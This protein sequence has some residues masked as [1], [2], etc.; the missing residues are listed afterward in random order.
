MLYNQVIPTSCLHV[1]SNR[2]D[3]L[4]TAMNDFCNLT[5][6]SHEDRLPGMYKYKSVHFKN[7]TKGASWDSGDKSSC[8]FFWLSHSADCFTA[9]SQ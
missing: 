4:F 8:V 1:P 6:P 2:L 3:T 5:K 7:R 9:L